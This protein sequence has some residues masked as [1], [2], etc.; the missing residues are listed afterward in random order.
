MAKLVNTL[1]RSYNGI[2]K[3]GVV[4]VKTK[5]EIAYYEENGFEILDESKTAT[6]APEGGDDTPK[7][8]K[9]TKKSDLAAWA[10]L[11]E[12]GEIKL[13]EE[14]TLKNMIEDYEV[15]MEAKAAAATSAPEGGDATG[16]AA[17]DNQ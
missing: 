3:G 17:G 4:E 5:E 2:E 16:G 12:N 11:P 6:S 14:M 9:F 13:D 10:I 15:Q 1:D 8:K 7:Y